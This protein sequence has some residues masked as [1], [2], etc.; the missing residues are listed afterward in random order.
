M[1]WNH[2]V[3][4]H[5][6]KNETFYQ[7]HECY[8]GDRSKGKRPHSITVD[9]VAPTGESIEDLRWA[10]EH[11]LSC[12]DKPV[13]KAKSYIKKPAIQISEDVKR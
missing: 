2:R 11:M 1:A 3:V 4:E 7:I 10:L 9:G 8:Y 6:Y 13:L 5:T 12:L